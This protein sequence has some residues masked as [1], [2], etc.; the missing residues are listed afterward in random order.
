MDPS[1]PFK[2]DHKNVYSYLQVGIIFCVYTTDTTE[3]T[4]KGTDVLLEK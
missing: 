2:K 3:G 4:N 1:H